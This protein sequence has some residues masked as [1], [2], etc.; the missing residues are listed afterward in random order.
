MELELT[1]KKAKILL[2]VLRANRATDVKSLTIRLKKRGE[3]VH[4]NYVRRVIDELGKLELIDVET[5]SRGFR[6]ISP[7]SDPETFKRLAKLFLTSPNKF[8]F[9]SLPY[10]KDK[11]TKE[12]LNSLANQFWAKYGEEIKKASDEILNNIVSQT[13]YL[14]ILEPFRN[15]VNTLPQKV[16]VNLLEIIKDSPFAIWVLMF[17]EEAMGEIKKQISPFVKNPQ[18]IYDELLRPLQDLLYQIDLKARRS[19]ADN[20]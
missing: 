6:R 5:F 1:D 4:M 18:W 19:Y 3:K 10:V 20:T 14:D 11:L 17:P 7:K 15:A 16:T 9:I 8:G 2:E 13:E 12:F